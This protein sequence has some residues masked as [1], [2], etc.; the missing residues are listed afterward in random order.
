MLTN[1]LP[2]YYYYFYKNIKNLQQ[3]TGENKVGN[4]IAYNRN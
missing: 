1:L 3:K 4:N 2:D